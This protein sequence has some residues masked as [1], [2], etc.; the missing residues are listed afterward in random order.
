MNFL[1]RNEN[2]CSSR[3]F[4]GTY[5]YFYKRRE[6]KMG[7]LSETEIENALKELPGWSLNSSH[8]LQRNLKF[9]DFKAAFS[10]MTHTA[11]EAEQNNHHP[12][13]FNVYNKVEVQLTTHDAGGITE[14]DLKLARFINKIAD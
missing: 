4:R 5:F 6:T 9:S 13:W 8:K 2:H 1:T 10:F 12:E 3:H 7:S 14:K 11:M